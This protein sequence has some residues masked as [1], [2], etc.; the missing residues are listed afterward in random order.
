MRVLR[1]IISILLLALAIPTVNGEPLLA[2]IK[3]GNSPLDNYYVLNANPKAGLLTVSRNASGKR[4]MDIKFNTIEKVAFT[5]PSEWE[6]AIALREK[7]DHKAAAEAFSK[8]AKEYKDVAGYPD[9]PPALASYYTLDALRR[10]G[11][12]DALNKERINALARNVTLSD[13]F[14]EEMKLFR[15]W[16]HVGQKAWKELLLVVNDY[17]LKLSASDDIPLPSMPPFKNLPSN[18]VA[19]L[20]Y[21]RATANENLGNDR[22]ALVDYARVYTVDLGRELELTR[23]GMLGSLRLLK[24]HP[25]MEFNYQIQKEAHALAILFNERFKRS[26]PAEFKEYLKPPPE[27]VDDENGK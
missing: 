18:L 14:S 20:C 26:L 7:R 1:N 15:A 10:L 5:M 22:E 2:Q 16:G 23:S 27:P 4:R 19:Q 12:Y 11:D 3:Y 9:S 17:E 6:D 8:I 25:E 13:K 24:K 21:L